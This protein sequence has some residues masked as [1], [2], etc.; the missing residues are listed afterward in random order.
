MYWCIHYIYHM[1][2]THYTL[3]TH[4]T[5]CTL[6]TWYALHPLDTYCMHCTHFVYHTCYEHCIHNTQQHARN[7]LRWVSSY[8]FL[9]RLFATDKH[10]SIQWFQKLHR[11]IYLRIVDKLISW[12]QC[13]KIFCG[14]NWRFFVINYSVSLWQDFIA[15][16]VPR[17]QSSTLNVLYSGGLQPYPQTPD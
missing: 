14:R 9:A 13:C 10:L 3:Y 12:G 7:A 1:K 16:V 8:I 17:V 6:N 11:L 15:K 5:Y 2:Y 4:Y